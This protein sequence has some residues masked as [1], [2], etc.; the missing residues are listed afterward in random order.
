MPVL[1]DGAG[2]DRVHGLSLG[3]TT[4]CDK[5][6][7]PA[8]L[9]ASASIVAWGGWA[10][11]ARPAEFEQAGERYRCDGPVRAVQYTEIPPKFHDGDLCAEQVAAVPGGVFPRRLLCQ[12]FGPCVLAAKEN[13]DAS[14]AEGVG[15]STS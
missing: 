1:F 14:G 4:A 3:R 7:V 8:Q 9:G 10:A 6:R 12:V 15:P 2:T 11:W 13:A 5:P